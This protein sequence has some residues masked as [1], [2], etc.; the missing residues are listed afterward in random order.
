MLILAVVWMLFL[1][2]EKRL[3]SY[4]P[5]HAAWYAETR[6]P[7]QVLK[8]IDRSILPFSDSGISLVRQMQAGANAITGVFSSN[9]DLL[10]KMKDATFGISSHAI[11]G[12]ETGYVF[13]LGLEKEKQ[14]RVLEFLEKRFRNKEGFRFEKRDYLGETIAEISAKG[15]RTFSLSFLKHAMVGSF[16][17]FLLEEVVRGSGVMLKPG[18]ATELSSDSRFSHLENKTLRIFL[19]TRFLPSFLKEFLGNP[20]P[21]L[22]NHSTRSMVFGLDGIAKLELDFQGFALSKP[23]SG[24]AG[25][26]LNPGL[27]EVLPPGLQV[28]SFQMATREMWKSISEIKNEEDGKVVLLEKALDD[29]ILLALLEGQGLKKY[30]HIL[31]ASVKSRPELDQVIQM[32]A[33]TSSSPHLY[34]EDYRGISLFKH[35]K[36]NLVSDFAGRPLAGWASSCYAVLGSRF[37]ICDQMELLRQCVDASLDKVT[38]SP[39]AS[40]SAL[41]SF[42]ASPGRMTPYFMENASGPLRKYLR[43]WLPLLRSVSKIQISDLG[44]SENPGITVSVKFRLPAIRRDSLQPLAKVFLDSTI[45]SGPFRMTDVSEENPVWIFEDVKKQAHFLDNQLNSIATQPLQD[46]WTSNPIPFKRKGSRANSVLLSLPNSTQVFS[47]SGEPESAFSFFPP[48]SLAALTQ[49]A[50]IDYDHS[51]DHRL[52][53]ASRYGFVMACDEVGRLLPGW[54]PRKLVHPLA[55][56]PRHIRVAG[57]DYLLFLDKTGQLLLTNRKGEMQ[58][59]FPFKLKGD[60]YAAMFIEAGLEEENSFVYCLSELG[61]MEKVSLTGKQASF[62]QLFRPEVNTRFSLCPDQKG[63]TFVVARQGLG[64][65]TLFDQS[66]RPILEYKS[67]GSRFEVKHFQFG[68]TNKIYAISDLDSKT[69]QLFNESGNPILKAPFQSSGAVDILPFGQAEGRYRILSCFENRVNLF[70]FTKD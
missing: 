55:Q 59:G 56:A 28:V 20:E 19:N 53:V 54:N 58:P 9:P 50:L 13:Y 41:F 5:D 32:L 10:E 37:V 17:G 68:S 62:L 33:G 31:V 45:V 22:M 44:E 15:G 1:K 64:S 24:N 6:Y 47:A 16:S 12:S 70:W 43:E 11:A 8:E 26:L 23:N 18:F 34:R 52:F 67:S 38:S 49:S 29:E 65:L 7:F 42:E 4:V 63:R 57:K 51:F 25:R 40:R 21:E 39:S 3:C 46:F 69:C 2:P 35:A 61:Q 66:Y 27:L 36:S 48:D 60:S 30:D 14:K